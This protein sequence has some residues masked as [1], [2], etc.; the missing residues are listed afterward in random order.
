MKAAQM[1]IV[2]A[3]AAALSVGCSTGRTKVTNTVVVPQQVEVTN[4]VVVPQQVVVTNTVVVPQQVVVT[5]TVVVAKP[6]VF[7]N[8]LETTRTIEVTNTVVQTRSVTNFVDRPVTN[9]IV[10]LGE[11]P[12]PAPLPNTLSLAVDGGATDGAKGEL[13]IALRA[14]LMQRGFV[15]EKSGRARASAVVAMTTSQKAN[16]A[17]WY[18]Y[19]GGAWARVEFGGTSPIVREKRF[20]VVGERKL[21]KAQAEKAVVKPLCKAVSA[22]IE[23]ILKERK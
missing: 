10:K 7:T 21:G 17:D 3:S 19:E 15:L 4:T 9:I 1:L 5:N 12:A 2:V 16:L 11:Q 8:T 6:V 18:V 20:E 22:W 13:L 14:E 23:Q